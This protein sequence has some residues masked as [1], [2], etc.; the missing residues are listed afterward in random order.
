MRRYTYKNWEAV[1]DDGSGK[2]ALKKKT[3]QRA[4][5]AQAQSAFKAMHV[6][7]EIQ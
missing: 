3:A 7:G 4:S 1:G 2:M 6:D 5:L